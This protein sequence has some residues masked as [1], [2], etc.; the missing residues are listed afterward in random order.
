MKSAVFL[1]QGPTDVRPEYI[2][3]TSEPTVFSVNADGYITLVK[4][5]LDHEN[6]L[7][8]NFSM[9]ITVRERNDASQSGSAVLL[10]QVLD[11]NDNSPKFDRSSYLMSRDPG[12]PPLTVTTVSQF[13]CCAAVPGAP[14]P[15]AHWSSRRFLPMTLHVQH[16]KDLIGYSPV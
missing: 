3:E 14:Q 7:H 4:A 1:L 15:V 11:I 2:Y 16:V 8:R 10:V 9:Q 5:D 13:A 12:A 6:P